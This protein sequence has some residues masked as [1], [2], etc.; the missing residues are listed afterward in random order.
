M[1]DV[2]CKIYIQFI[3]CPTLLRNTKKQCYWVKSVHIF[4]IKTP[5]IDWPKVLYCV[6][7]QTLIYYMFFVL[8][9]ALLFLLFI[10]FEIKILVFFCPFCKPNFPPE[11]Q[12]KIISYNR[13]LNTAKNSYIKGAVCSIWRYLAV[14]LQIATNWNSSCVPSM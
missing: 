13:I 9:T 12:P 7:R 3:H 14:R 2:V 6:Q 5:I 8:C 4:Y 10:P 1:G 11:D